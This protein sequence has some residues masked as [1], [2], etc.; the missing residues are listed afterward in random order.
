MARELDSQVTFEDTVLSEPGRKTMF[1]FTPDSP[2][3]Y[4]PINLR[5]FFTRGDRR[6]ILLIS[7][8]WI[9]TCIF[10]MSFGWWCAANYVAYNTIFGF[11]IGDLAFTIFLPL[12]LCLLWVLLWGYWWG[13]IPAYLATL[14]VAL[15]SHMPLPWAIVFACT[16][17]ITLAVYSI[18]YRALP[19]QLTFRR[20][21][22][23]LFFAII[24]L[25]SAVLS[26]AG[27]FIWSHT[28][29]VELNTVQLIDNWYDWWLNGFVTQ[30][31]FV[32]P[33][34]FFVFPFIEKLKKNKVWIPTSVKM[35][36]RDIIVL[37]G[38]VIASILLFCYLTLQLNQSLFQAAIESGE[39]TQLRAAFETTL[40]SNRAFYWVMGATL[41]LVLLLGFQFYKLWTNALADAKAEAEFLARTDFLTGL[42]NRRAF[43]EFAVN[44]L[45]Q[46]K[47]YNR[48][49]VIAIM[50]ID[51]FKI[52]NDTWGHDKGDEVL[53]AVSDVIS[54]QIRTA[55]IVARFGGEEFIL[56]MPE[57]RLEQARIS[58]E[59][60][61]EKVEELILKGNDGED[62][63]LSI[64]GGIACPSSIEEDLDVVIRKA[65]DT[66]Y[67]A[68][69]NGRNRIEG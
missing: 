15:V 10:C 13:A 20:V 17:P 58:V 30:V 38:L 68:K 5:L 63:R 31:L 55:D 35:A 1:L 34:L 2:G 12:P 36:K 56:M 42:H 49:Y 60:I 66:L 29:S 51:H 41:L 24:G 59:R 4:R 19:V 3:L 39:I 69:Q 67:K 57:T 23:I 9:L 54:E 33:I 40:Q 65:D 64:S 47:R 46:A 43:F 61:R 28:N 26:A 16:N 50:D 37:L 14:T 45:E 32:G 18:V 44:I 6:E 53:K 7:I 27:S 22:P 11:Q 21:G 48:P 62:I 8:A 52:I 25:L